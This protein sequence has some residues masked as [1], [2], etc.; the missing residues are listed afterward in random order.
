MIRAGSQDDVQV[1]AHHGIAADIDRENRCKQLESFADPLLAIV[2][3]VLGEGIDTAEKRP[4][5]APRH[6][7]ID[8]DLVGR[9]DVRACVG[10]HG[11][12]L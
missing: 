10:G 6:A 7:M 4:A 11:R 8:T 9:H 5:H 1:I 3:V 12:S 2:V